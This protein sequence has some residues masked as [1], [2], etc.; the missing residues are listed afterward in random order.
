MEENYHFRFNFGITDQ[1]TCLF[2]IY[3][4]YDIKPLELYLISFIVLA[5][6]SPYYHRVTCNFRSTPEAQPAP[7]HLL[8]T[9][10]GMNTSKGGDL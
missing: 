2:S 6:S 7:G 10:A 5:L 1:V 8:P 9:W 4:A 3:G